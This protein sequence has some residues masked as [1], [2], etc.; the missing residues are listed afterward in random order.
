MKPTAIS[1]KRKTKHLN[2]VHEKQGTKTEICKEFGITNPALSTITK[3]QS[4]NTSMLE[5]N[6]FE[7]ERKRM[8][9]AKHEDFEKSVTVS[10]NK[11]DCRMAGLLLLKKQLNWK[12]K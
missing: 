1:F 10:L 4:R 7:L 9:T 3:N 8:R 12:N 6:V 5:D 11:K 2:A